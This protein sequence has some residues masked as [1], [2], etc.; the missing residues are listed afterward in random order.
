MAIVSDIWSTAHGHLP[1]EELI[2]RHG[3]HGPAEG[4]LSSSVWRDDPTPLQRLV[5]L[6][7]DRPQPGSADEANERATMQ[8]A[9]LAA[10]PA[11]QRPA[12]RQV[13]RLAERRILLRGICKRSFLQSLDVCRATARRAGQL[14]AGAGLLVDH[15]D[16]FFLTADELIGGEP[17]DVQELIRRR[18]ERWET[19]RELELPQAW[20]GAATPVAPGTDDH[21]SD[22]DDA[23]Q[24]TGV[25]SGTVTGRVRV[26]HDP[27]FGEVEPGEVLVAPITDPSWSSIMFL[28]AALVVDIGGALSHAAVVAREMRIPCVVNTRHGTRSLRT[29]DLVRVDGSSG[30]VTVLERAEV[31]A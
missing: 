13:L 26:V 7:A 8:R 2:R 17:P 1:M 5:Q 22:G 25:S 10:L 31:G 12:A 29:G 30:R 4:E 11:W 23:L 24:G 6:Y 16:V 14:L 9:L 3:F 21:A 15:D 20:R 19:Y 27:T 18:R 28:S